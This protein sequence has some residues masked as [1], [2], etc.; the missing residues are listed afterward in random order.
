M[1]RPRKDDQLDGTGPDEGDAVNQQTDDGKRKSRRKNVAVEMDTGD[2][3]THS[4]QRVTRGRAKK[5]SNV[6]HEVVEETSEEISVEPETSR[7]G[8]PKKQEPIER[9][10]LP[11]ETAAVSAA[12]TA[13]PKEGPRPQRGRPKKNLEQPVE[14]ESNVEVHIPIQRP[15][16][17]ENDVSQPVPAPRIAAPGKGRPKKQ[18]AQKN[19]SVEANTET[20]AMVADVTPQVEVDDTLN[21][22]P[23]SLGSMGAVGQG[24]A[25]KQSK[26]TK[27]TAEENGDRQEETLMDIE[28]IEASTETFG[29]P[30]R[31]PSIQQQKAPSRRK[32]SPKRSARP[33]GDVAEPQQFTIST[34]AAI[35]ISPALDSRDENE[36][37]PE[38]IPVP[39]SRK[40]RARKRSAAAEGNATS[41]ENV[42]PET[43]EPPKTEAYTHLANKLGE[44]LHSLVSWRAFV[45]GDEMS[46][47]DGFM[48]KVTKAENRFMC[49]IPG[50]TKT[51]GFLNPGGIKYHLSHH[52]HEIQAMISAPESQ[53]LLQQLA[54]NQLP[55]T[56]NEG[57]ENTVPTS[58]SEVIISQCSELKRYEYPVEVSCGYV[59]PGGFT[60]QTLLLFDSLVSKPEEIPIYI[61]PAV[62]GSSNEPGITNDDPNTE[63][64][65]PVAGG[66]GR[67]YSKKYK[68]VLPTLL[69]TWPSDE[70]YMAEEPDINMSPDLFPSTEDLTIVSRND[71]DKHLPGRDIDVYLRS[72]R[73]DANQTAYSLPKQGS[74]VLP[75][76]GSVWGLDWANTASDGNQYLAVSG[77]R[78]TTDDHQF[79][80]SPQTSDLQGCIQI[81]NCGPL[82]F[83]GKSTITPRLELCILHNF[84]VVF[85]LRWAPL[86][87]KDSVS[88]S[89][90]GR[91]PRLGWLAACFG[92]GGISV[93]KVSENPAQQREDKPLQYVVA[94]DSAISSISCVS[95]MDILQAD[96]ESS[97]T[98]ILSTGLDGRL[99][100][101]DIRFLWRSVQMYRNRG[102]MTGAMCVPAL[103][104]VFL[105]DSD[106]SVRLLKR[107][108]DDNAKGSSTEEGEPGNTRSY[109]VSS[110]SACI[111]SID[112]ARFFPFVVSG[113]AD[114]CVK[115][116]NVNRIQQRTH[117][118]TPG[119]LYRLEW[120]AEEKRLIY[121]NNIPDERMNQVFTKGDNPVQFFPPEVAIQ[122][123]ATCKNQNC[124]SWVASG[125]TA[126]I[127][128]VEYFKSA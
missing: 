79:L 89:Q 19:V 73:G 80:G 11:L 67:S 119:F 111:W 62:V 54:N 55:A 57:G 12:E 109:G 26:K 71:I 4:P 37:E 65:I 112:N 32:V 46:M 97:T 124:A 99:L 76:G 117:K 91:L 87:A 42:P 49:P 58:L 85:E 95:K 72:F 88:D 120:D 38:V 20:D 103:G 63:S 6:M 115:L 82:D 34:A 70:L 61:P 118:P 100:C 81:W 68:K 108:D 83:K 1:K 77:Y 25:G 84:G 3:G 51:E 75:I 40:E 122:K 74:C 2:A 5:D 101:H 30:E 23:K 123:V 116:S 16:Q 96:S 110:H 56:V 128:R 14:E 52:R 93:W 22:L 104:C 43:I 125:G 64:N 41:Q 9:G 50:C 86:L 27:A 29:M 10:E 45:S 90:T 94:H 17:T 8:R 59:L 28:N 78:N 47:E 105:T 53:V 127:V 39:V 24:R 126:G 36:S 98:F 114:G 107:E 69:A 44:F 121:I 15:Q 21:E 92:D 13:K 33:A 48:L 113:S 18:T 7:R 35:R 60:S 102:F 106:N 31:E 66:G